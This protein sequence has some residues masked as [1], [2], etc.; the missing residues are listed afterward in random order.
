MGI[1]R[2]RGGVPLADREFEKSYATGDTPWDSGRPSAELVRVL[3]AGWMPGK[4]VLEIGCGTGMNAVE[5]ARLGEQLTAIDMVNLG[6]RRAKDKPQR[7]ELDMDFH[8]EDAS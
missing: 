1:S 5:L 6:V 2:L 8:E 3:Y 7:A 4:T